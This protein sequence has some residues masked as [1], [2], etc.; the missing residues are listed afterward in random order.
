MRFQLALCALLV[1]ATPA[2]P[3]RAD[4]HAVALAVREGGFEPARL[5]VPVGVRVRL[6]VSNETASAI[7]FESFELNRE[8]VVP[9]GQ[10]ATVY[11]SGL[12]AGEYQ[13]FDDFHQARRGTLLVR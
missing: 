13:F 8:R 12:S 6:E 7:E 11:L 9:P 5:E 2:V 10:K 1:L 3:A 4:D